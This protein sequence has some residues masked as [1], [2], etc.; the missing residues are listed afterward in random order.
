MARTSISLHSMRSLA[1][2]GVG[3]SIVAAAAAA[4]LTFSPACDEPAH[5]GFVLDCSEEG[6]YDII[7]HYS[8]QPTLPTWYQYGDTTPDASQTP[9]VAL[10]ANIYSVPW[11]ATIENGG[12]CGSQVA[13]V[14][15]SSGFH[16]YGSGFGDYGIQKSTQG[17]TS[18]GCYLPDGETA[19]C[20]V[21]YSGYE[22]VAFWAR[23]PGADHT[24]SVTIQ[25]ADAQSYDSNGAATNCL[26]QSNTIPAPD[27]GDDS[28]LPMVTVANPTGMT[29]NGTPTNG[30]GGVQLPVGTCGNNFVFPLVTS[31]NWQLYKIPFSAFYQTATPNK[32][33][34]GFDPSTFFWMGVIVPKE[35]QLELWI[36]ELGFYPKKQAG[37]G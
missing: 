29:T 33:P 3:G 26:Y 37:G 6:S 15:R 28:G 19:N 36:D 2:A 4:A 24:K 12:R 18:L 1:R 11:T 10:D 34:R 7:E 14:L 5:A 20:S 30:G 27:G 8:L 16:D 22:G 9:G 21:D 31:E 35:A 17:N 13:M 23:S 32:E 25:I